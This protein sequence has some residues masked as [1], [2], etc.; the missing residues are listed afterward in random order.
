MKEGRERDIEVLGT[1]L[2]VCFM[3]DI[4]ITLLMTTNDLPLIGHL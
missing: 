1:S 2:L 4:D 3:F